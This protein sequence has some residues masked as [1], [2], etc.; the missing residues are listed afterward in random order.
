MHAELS[1][2]AAGGVKGP[3]GAGA[4]GAA[5]AG[6]GVG[7]GGASGGKKGRVGSGQALPFAMV[8]DGKALSYALH[9]SLAPLFLEVGLQC[10]AVICCRVS[11][12]QKAQVG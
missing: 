1:A 6:K 7:A 4:A 5:G 8:I 2:A 9:E 11:P 12:K 3:A 10:Q